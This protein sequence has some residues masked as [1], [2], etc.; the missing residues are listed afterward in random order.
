LKEPTVQPGRTRDSVP[1][2]QPRGDGMSIRL[3][4]NGMGRALLP[5]YPS[6]AFRWS[7]TRSALAMMVNAGFTAA[8]EGKK[9]PST[10]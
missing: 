9:L 3:R 4:V 6:L 5:F 1:F 7:P 2:Q 10:T 8:L